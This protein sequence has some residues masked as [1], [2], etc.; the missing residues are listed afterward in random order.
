MKNL[1]EVYQTNL[2][3]LLFSGIPLKIR[4]FSIKY[5]Y[6]CGRL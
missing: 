2:K 6:T 1:R 3:I 5:F 4:I